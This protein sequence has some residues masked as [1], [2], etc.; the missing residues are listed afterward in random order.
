MRMITRIRVALEG[1]GMLTK[2]EESKE[3]EEEE[4]KKVSQYQPVE[5]EVKNYDSHLSHRRG[6][7]DSNTLN[8]NKYI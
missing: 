2:K 3:E 5:E 6:Q 8:V 1:E 7:E 4:E